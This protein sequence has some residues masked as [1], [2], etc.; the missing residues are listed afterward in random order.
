MPTS[1]VYLA[2]VNMPAKSGVPQDTV[3]HDFVFTTSDNLHANRLAIAGLLDTFYNTIPTGGTRAVGAYLSDTISRV[4]KPTVKFYDITT[5]LS[6]SAHG[7]PV[8]TFTLTAVLPAA[9]GANL[10]SELAVCLSFNHDYGTDV[11]FGPGSRPRARDRGRIFIGP[12]LQL[13]MDNDT[14]TRRPKVTAACMTDLTKAATAL[15]A[16]VDPGWCVWSRRNAIARTVTAGW[17]D[18]AFDIQRRRGELAGTR[19]TF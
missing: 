9:S 3:I 17:V 7:S 13:A 14:T 11:E 19:T 16:S 2:A 6:G 5:H 10:P 1:S 18:D 8:D 15:K 4:A 12:L